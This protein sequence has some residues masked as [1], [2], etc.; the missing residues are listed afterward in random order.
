MHST[1]YTS[2]LSSQFHM[3]WQIAPHKYLHKLTTKT[4]T[5]QQQQ[6]QKHHHTDGQNVSNGRSPLIHAHFIR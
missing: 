5:K 4:S 3:L 1:E 2:H 6:Q